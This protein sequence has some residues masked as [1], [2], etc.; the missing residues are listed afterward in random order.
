MKQD[1]LFCKH[2]LAMHL[3]AAMDHFNTLQVTDKEFTELLNEN[4]KE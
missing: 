4:L 2:Q 1:W 3:S